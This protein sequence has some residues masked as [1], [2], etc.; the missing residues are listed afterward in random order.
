MISGELVISNAYFFELLN[1]NLALYFFAVFF[2]KFILLLFKVTFTKASYL[3]LV[4]SP[5]VKSIT[6][7]TCINLSRE[8]II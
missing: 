7:L 4:E 3:S 1:I 2:N 5:E 8:W 6:F